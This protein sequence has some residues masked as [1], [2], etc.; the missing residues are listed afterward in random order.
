MYILYLERSYSTERDGMK[1]AFSR[2]SLSAPGRAGRFHC[3]NKCIRNIGYY[4]DSHEKV[5]NFCGH[6]VQIAGSWTS[7]GSIGGVFHAKGNGWLGTGSV[8]EDVKDV[9]PLSPST[10]VGAGKYCCQ[11]RMP[12]EWGEGVHF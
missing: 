5:H 4:L 11:Y 7:V 2:I 10:R 12:A 1:H 9:S 8:V 6:E 3:V